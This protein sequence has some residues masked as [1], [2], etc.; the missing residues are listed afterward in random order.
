MGRL[1]PDLWPFDVPPGEPVVTTTHVTSGQQPIL[2][3]THERDG[4]DVIW[5]FHCGNGD[6]RPEILQLVRLDEIVR[7]DPTVR[8]VASLPVGHRAQRQTGSEEWTMLA[9]E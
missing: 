9:E 2:L 3:V 1:K 7:L 5:Q 8:S 6:Y 4:A